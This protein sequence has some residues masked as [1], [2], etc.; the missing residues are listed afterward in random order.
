LGI[1]G[2]IS[3]LQAN[4]TDLQLDQQNDVA[5]QNNLSNRTTPIFGVGAYYS[6]ERF[7][8]G[9]SVPNLVQSDYSTIQNGSIVNGKSHRHYFFTMG[10]LIKLSEDLDFKPTTLVKFTDGAPL[11]G[12]LTASFVIRKKLFLRSSGRRT[13]WRIATRNWQ[14]L[15]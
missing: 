12:N 13:R 7:Y 14:K 1:S 3:L 2:G 8:V 4:L 11:Q 15:V 10:G 5:F 9:A 6:T